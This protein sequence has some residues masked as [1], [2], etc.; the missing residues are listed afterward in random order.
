MEEEVLHGGLVNRVVR[1]GDTVRR[2]PGDC[3]ATIH[4]LLAHVA[5]GWTRATRQK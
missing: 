5:R 1:V 2:I 4:R 3:T